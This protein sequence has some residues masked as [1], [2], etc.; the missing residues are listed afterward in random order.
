MIQILKQIISII[1]LY[2]YSPIMVW[3]FMYYNFL[4]KN[5]R[6]YSGFFIPYRNTKIMF[7]DSSILELHGT[8]RLGIPSMPGS[9]VVSKLVIRESGRFCVNTKCDIMEGCDIQIH[10][11]G[12]FTVDDFH[13]NISLEVSCGEQ[14]R[15]VG[16]V[17]AGRHVRLK[18]FNGHEVS[19]SGYPRSKSI[20]IEDNVWICT[21]ASI[22]PGVHIQSGS[23]IADNSNVTTNVPARSFVQG[24]P[25]A[26]IAD[27]ITFKM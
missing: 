7:S 4:S 19:Y 16:E 1:R 23:V 10:K 17:S 13:S 8:L 26:V 11:N 15:L 9:H 24:N 2:K 5:V 6:R 21:G 14:I 3:K 27:N 18:D 12:I 22:N 20:V 25:A